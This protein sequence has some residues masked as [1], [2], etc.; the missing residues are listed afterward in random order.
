MQE[1]TFVK[2]QTGD[3]HKDLSLCRIQRDAQKMFELLAERNPF[4]I[5]TVLI[6]LNSGEVAIVF[7]TQ[8]IEESLIQGMTGT[9]TFY[10]KFRKKDTVITIRTNASLNNKDS[11]LEVDPQL[12]FQKI[13]YFHSTGRNQ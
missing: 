11:V 13:N 12:F 2:Y 8:A 4:G 5:Y 6:N 9:L 7:D 3:Q 10:C 1:F